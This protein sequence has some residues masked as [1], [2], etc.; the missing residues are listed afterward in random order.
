MAGITD[1]FLRKPE[2]PDS[3][4]SSTTT[5]YGIALA[6]SENGEVLVCMNEESCEEQASAVVEAR[7]EYEATR[8]ESALDAYNLAL[9]AL[10]DAASSGYD[11]F[12]GEELDEDDVIGGEDEDVESEELD[13]E[14]DD[15][16]GLLFDDWADESNIPEFDDDEEVDDDSESVDEEPPEDDIEPE[17]E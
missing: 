10:V 17:D 11:D 12:E 8:S 15:D 4:A 16:S 13:E 6:D 7:E 3:S 14:T 2:D 1:L 5:I 9:A